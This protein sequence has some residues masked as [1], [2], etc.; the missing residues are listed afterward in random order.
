MLQTATPYDVF[1]SWSSK[2][3]IQAA[4]VRHLPN[5]K[6]PEVLWRPLT[7]SL[8]HR[9]STTVFLHIDTKYE[10][11]ELRDGLTHWKVNEVSLRSAISTKGPLVSLRVGIEL[12]RLKKVELAKAYHQLSALKK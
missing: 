9:T 7:R 6:K 1:M 5:P 12:F 4:R 3:A 2:P 11:F 10:N 8:G